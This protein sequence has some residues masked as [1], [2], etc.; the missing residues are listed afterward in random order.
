MPDNTGRDFSP[1]L[2]DS[3]QQ[4]ERVRH[5]L[6]STAEDEDNDS[7]YIVIVFDIDVLKMY[8]SSANQSQYG[9]LLRSESYAESE[10]R[11]FASTRQEP[12]VFLEG[13]R[14]MAEILGNFIVWE[15]VSPFLV[16]PTHIEEL[17]RVCRAI[18]RDAF[19][20]APKMKADLEVELLNFMEV[21]RGEALDAE[22]ID[23]KTTEL[24]QK[25]IGVVPQVM[26]A[27]RLNA[28]FLKGRIYSLEA[29]PL[30]VDQYVPRL[31]DSGVLSDVDACADT[32]MDVLTSEHGLKPDRFRKFRADA[33]CLAY[34]RWLNLQEIKI[35]NKTAKFRLVT[36]APHLHWLPEKLKRMNSL[37]EEK[38]Y[39]DLADSLHTVLRHPLGFLDSHEISRLLEADRKSGDQ[40]APRAKLSELLA[41]QFN[42]EVSGGDDPVLPEA[43]AADRVN[44]A[45]VELLKVLR[46]ART[47]QLL[48]P[49][50]AWLRQVVTSVADGGTERLDKVLAEAIVALVPSFLVSLGYLQ[51]PTRSRGLARNLPPIIFSKFAAAETVFHALRSRPDRG[52]ALALPDQALL[53]EVVRTD[54]SLY[55]VL[56]VF[57]LIHADAGD[58]RITLRFAESAA[59]VAEQIGQLRA[60]SPV[61][62][63]GMAN[64][65]FGEEA[66]YLACVAKRLHVRDERSF[67]DLDQAMKYLTAARNAYRS[68]ELSGYVE[69]ATP[70]RF[71]SEEISLKVSM[72]FAE[73]LAQKVVSEGG[74]ELFRSILNQLS[75]ANE[76]K[77]NFMDRSY[78]FEYVRQQLFVSASQLI[79]LDRYGSQAGMLFRVHAKT[80][81][82]ADEVASELDM[83]W[84]QFDEQCRTLD[85]EA[86]ANPS[87][88]LPRVSDWVRGVWYATGLEL[89]RFDRADRKTKALE[90]EAALSTDLGALVPHRLRFSFIRQIVQRKVVE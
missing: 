5:W 53:A 89:N 36:G 41:K 10:R 18:F 27:L 90:V 81:S 88:D 56:L 79:L 73:R 21:S 44:H 72:I 20:D 39:G 77:S 84:S 16:S 60:R 55:T 3:L 34:L 43:D 51:L 83:L 74:A 58:W 24:L 4:L 78:A 23:Q 28:A 38:I 45:A 22:Q 13:E 1:M 66:N 59:L 14:E 76:I 31:E 2:S 29:H 37:E 33:E 64:H 48:S 61:S 80:W 9:A 63:V 65:I 6:K 67:V 50:R 75:S 46:K 52:V 86:A 70:I 47:R 82:E 42:D 8:S 57:A 87:A 71:E 68:C 25:V 69:K 15:R 40:E 19:L 11:L 17:E 26:E 85:G 49:D 12:S 30:N 35:D 7:E 62:I 54:A 32:L